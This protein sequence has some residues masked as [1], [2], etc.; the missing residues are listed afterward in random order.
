MTEHGRALKDKDIVCLGHL[1]RVFPLLD[2]LND[3]GCER[4]RAGNREL[5]FGDYCKLVLLYIWNPLIDSLRMLQEAG[6][7]T[8][9]AKALGVRRFSLGSFSETPRIFEPERLEPIIEELAGQLQPPNKDPRLCEL[10]HALTLVDSTVLS[11]L[12]RLARSAVGVDARCNTSRDGGAVYGWRLHTQL[13]LDTFS[14]R[15]LERRGARN[16]GA[17]RENNVLRQSLESGRCYVGD[18]GYADRTLFDDIVARDSSYVVR[19]REDSVMQVLEERLLSQEA[20]DAHVVRDAMVR[21]GV[22]GAGQMGHPVRIVAIQVQPHPKRT[23]K[24]REGVTKGTRQSELLL[25]ATSLL[26]LPAELVALIYLYRYTIELFF[27]IFKQLLGARHLLSQREEGID[28]QV[29]CTVIVCLLLCLMTRKRPSKSNRN[30]I[31][32][33]PIGLASE[34]ELIDHLNR[35]DNT[36]VK[37]RAKDE[38][39]KKLGV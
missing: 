11:A 35:P 18:G 19:L 39:W 21:L 7:L 12:T 4:D 36:G 8:S 37:L 31:G 17:N 2:R 28:V 33:Y 30:M 22:E 23:R 15:H 25:L 10:K 20:L 24:A 32:W 16:A 29:N 1:R 26:D 13:D 5:F 34:Q 14:P 3:V 9:V 27:R 6:E 38:L